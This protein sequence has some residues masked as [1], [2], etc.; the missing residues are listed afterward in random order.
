MSNISS[1]NFIPFGISNVISFSHPESIPYILL[2][3]NWSTSNPFI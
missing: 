2:S 1:S 3:S